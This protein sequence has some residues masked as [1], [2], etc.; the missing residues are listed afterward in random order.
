MSMAEIGGG[1]WMPIAE[2]AR[3]A[4]ISRQA[5]HKNVLRWQKQGV[6]S[7]R[8]GPK[9]AVLVNQVVYDRLRREVADPAQEFRNFRAPIA[10]TESELAADETEDVGNSP[11]KANYHASRAEREAYQ[12]EN[13]RLDLEERLG[14]LVDKDEV[15]RRLMLVFRRVRDGTMAFLATQTGRAFAAT[16]ERAAR[17]IML[18]EGRRHFEAI[19]VELDRLGTADDDGDGEFPADGSGEEEPGAPQT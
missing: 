8:P 7:T 4:G 5:A 17:A 15:E 11:G 1:V 3:R 10:Q 2:I 6:L 16:D 18:S 9:G 19:A 12:A 14:I 13:A